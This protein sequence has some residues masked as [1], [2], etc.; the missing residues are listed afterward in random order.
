MR[1]IGRVAEEPASERSQKLAHASSPYP[2]RFFAGA[3][4]VALLTGASGGAQ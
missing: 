1:V 2:A 4:L 3:A